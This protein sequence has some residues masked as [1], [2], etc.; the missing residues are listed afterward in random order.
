V[1]LLVQVIGQPAW[2]PERPQPI[3]AARANGVAERTVETFRRECLDRVIVPNEDRLQ[4]ILREFVTY[5]DHDRR[6]RS[7]RL[8]TPDVGE[9][10]QGGVIRCRP[11]LS[12]LHHSYELAA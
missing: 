3:R 12:G 1:T 4:T 9:R 10:L 7:L 5:Y 11:I 6:N 8:E 2:H